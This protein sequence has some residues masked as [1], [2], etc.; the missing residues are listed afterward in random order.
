[1]AARAAE[2]QAQL[3]QFQQLLDNLQAEV[4]GLR[5]Q[6]NG[7]M[8]TSLDSK[9]RIKLSLKVLPTQQTSLL[10]LPLQLHYLPPL[11]RW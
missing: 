10:H 5:D 1:M 6:N 4:N 3:A 7:Q 8:R 2:V 11:L 9:T